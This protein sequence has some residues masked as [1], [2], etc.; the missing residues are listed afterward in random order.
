MA[1]LIFDNQNAVSKYFTEG[2]LPSLP[3]QA[4]DSIDVSDDLI[5]FCHKMPEIKL[6]NKD[7]QS[8]HGKLVV[9]K[10]S[11]EGRI[12]DF[13]KLWRTNFLTSMDPK[14]LPLGWRVEHTIERSFGVHSKFNKKE[15]EA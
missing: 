12:S 14:F 7:K 5:Q 9:E 4:K 3:I 15:D 8:P 11:E 2:L 13:I 10:I 6:S 1:T